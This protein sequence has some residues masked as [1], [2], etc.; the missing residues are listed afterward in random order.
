MLFQNNDEKKKKV[1]FM[2]YN[3]MP[4]ITCVCR[5]NVKKIHK[6]NIRGFPKCKY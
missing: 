6:C 1:V 3:N 5:K 2:Q 4:Q